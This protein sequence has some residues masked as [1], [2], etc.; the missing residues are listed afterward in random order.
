MEEIGREVL[1]NVGLT[2]RLITYAVAIVVMYFFITGIVKRYKMWKIGKPSPVDFKKTLGKRIGYFI[3]GVLL[4]GQFP[5]FLVN[6]R[7]FIWCSG[8]SI[9]RSR[10]D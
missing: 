1:W 5:V 8:I 3:S 4:D 7:L 6:Q 10:S 2:G 9:W